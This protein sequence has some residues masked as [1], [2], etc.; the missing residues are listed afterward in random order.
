MKPENAKRRPSKFL[1]EQCDWVGTNPLSAPHPF[2][3]DEFIYGCRQCGKVSYL[4]AACEVVGCR[5]RIAG[6]TPTD[7]GYKLLCSKHFE[8]VLEG[9]KEEKTGG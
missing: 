4:V 7:D 8:K 1:C 5:S 6:G 2:I 9:Q 3:Q